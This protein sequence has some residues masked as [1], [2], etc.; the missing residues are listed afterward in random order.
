ML[1][2][3]L[4]EFGVKHLELVLTVEIR[5]I[6]ESLDEVKSIIPANVVV[7][8]AEE[9]GVANNHTAEKHIHA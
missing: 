3:D 2:E 4:P 1:P 9:R 7:D 8:H 6:V 5:N